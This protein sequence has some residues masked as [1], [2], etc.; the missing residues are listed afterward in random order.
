MDSKPFKKSLL[1]SLK[2]NRKLD[3]AE[4][5]ALSEND[6]E[7]T[8][9]ND[10]QDSFQFPIL[11]AFQNSVYDSQNDLSVRDDE[12]YYQFI[13]LFVSFRQPNRSKRPKRPPK[14]F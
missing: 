5:P 12:L 8:K 4:E 7:S 10:R 6:D 13:K 11:S 1:L 2:F 3:S 14:R 9:Q